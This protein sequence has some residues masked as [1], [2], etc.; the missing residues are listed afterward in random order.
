MPS[1]RTHSP[2]SCQN[3]ACPKVFI[4]TDKRQKYCTRQCQINY[5]NDKKSK[6]L[7]SDR[8][9]R[10]LEESDLI[11]AYLYDHAGCNQ[12][13]IHERILRLQK[14]DLSLGTLEY[15]KRRGQQIRWYLQYG[16]ICTHSKELDY[17]I[18]SRQEMRP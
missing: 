4:P 13:S 12:Y 8:Y 11:L 6:K 2:K 7:E 15:D 3:P 18:V 9:E 5:N 17:F 1:K 14:V 16:L 10:R